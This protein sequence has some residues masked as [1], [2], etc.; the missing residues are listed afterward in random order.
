MSS[1][2]RKTHR[3]KSVSCDLLSSPRS[4]SS[5]QNTKADIEA[6]RFVAFKN[7]QGS[8][9]LLPVELKELWC[10]GPT[11]NVP[12]QELDAVQRL[13]SGVE[14]TERETWVSDGSRQSLS[15]DGV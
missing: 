6:L 10:Q 15:A 8:R 11:G 3:S 7:K 9:P 12:K 2:R 13:L 4:Y 5:I 1:R 14:P